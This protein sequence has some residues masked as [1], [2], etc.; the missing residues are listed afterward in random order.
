MS[1][2]RRPSLTGVGE[3]WTMASTRSTDDFTRS[4][5][6]ARPGSRAGEAAFSRSWA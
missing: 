6:R 4:M 5:G 1:D 2:R 3:D